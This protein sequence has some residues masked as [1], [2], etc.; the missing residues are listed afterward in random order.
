VSQK[1]RLPYALPD[2]GKQEIK[3][4]SRVIRSG[5]LTSGPQT[6]AF[7]EEFKS[8]VGAQHALAVNSCTSALH[9]I[10]RALM[11]GPGDA[12]ILPTTTFIASAEALCYEGALPLLVDVHRQSMLLDP[13]LTGSYIEEKC[14]RSRQGEWIHKESGRR[15][16]ALVAV[17]LGGR[18]CDL[19]GLRALCREYRLKL[20]EDAAHSLPSFYHGQ[21]GREMI[22][23]QSE[24][25]A[26]SFYATKNLATGEGGMLTLRDARLA[27]RLRRLRLHGILGQTWGRA[28]WRYDVLEFGYKYNLCDILAAIGRIQ[29]KRLPEMQSRRHRLAR[30]YQRQL[31]GL[32][33]RLIDAPSP[34]TA[35][36]LFTVELLDE[37][38]ISRDD[39]VEGLYAR[40]IATSLHFIPLHRFTH[41]KKMY[42]TRSR[43]FPNAE[44]L[45][46]RVLSLPLYPS[47]PLATVKR[48][49]RAIADLIV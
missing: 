19:D 21:S 31:A 24:F 13:A 30:E 17:H 39:L 1:D 14:R 43:D 8:F 22:G 29:L 35:Q 20:I 6:S 27:D 47:L 49:C 3:A 2:L 26:F 34:G 4:A 25:A 46:K 48:V 23:A 7:E 10:S 42:K 32:P 41:F 28:R 5:W 36:H 18:A 15:L 45:F 37:G 11:L 16:R 12:I 40:G 38:R 44:A 9:L 33:L